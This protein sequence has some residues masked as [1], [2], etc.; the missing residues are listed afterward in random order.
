MTANRT[1]KNAKMSTDKLSLKGNGVIL[2][3]LAMIAMMVMF[4]EIMLVPALPTIAKDFTQDQE[5]ISWVLSAYLLVGAVATPILGKLGDMYGKK[6]VMMVAMVVYTFGL[7]GCA[8]SWSIPSLIMFRAI[9]GVGMGMFPLAFGI[10]RDTFPRRMVPMAIGIIS[11]MFSVGVSVGLLGGGWLV[12]VMS[13]KNAFW[14]VSPLM[15]LMTVIIYFKIKDDHV[16][17]RSKLD[18]P[19]A[20]FLGGGVLALLLALTQGGKWGWTDAKIVGLFLSSAILFIVF[21]AWEKRA[22]DPIVSLK[23][24]TNPGVAG[25]NFAALF[26]GLSMFMFFQTMPFLLESPKEVGGFGVIDTFTVGLYMFPSAIAQLIFAPLAGK[27]SKSVGA[28]NILISGMGITA[29]GYLFL[30]M[31]H[32]TIPEIMLGV[33]IMGIGLGFAMVS[34]INVIALSTKKE[35]FG[36]ASGMNTLF[37][38]VGGS[39]GPVL[40]TVI[41]QQFM[42]QY[43][44]PFGPMLPSADGYAWAWTA[45]MIFTLIGLVV[46]LVMRPGKGM[47]YDDEEAKVTAVEE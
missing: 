27:W 9:Q 42:I 22:T 35:E 43:Q 3:L 19:G 28:D 6:K 16:T 10:V 44:P 24:L 11:A 29:I 46:A 1:L 17:I 33:F 26:V 5:W 2:V 34:L 39:I 21:I 7:I 23:L 32:G 37:R 41:L 47:S 13:W 15:A 12:S 40:A 36:I 14:V 4:I 30:I 25:A 45:G 8:F 18:L 38:V 31:L 20:A